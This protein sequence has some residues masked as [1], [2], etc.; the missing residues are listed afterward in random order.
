MLFSTANLGY[1]IP[2]IFIAMAI[3]EAMHAFIA[4]ALGDTTAKDMGRLTLNP[5]KHID[6][7]YTL[8]LPVVLIL[9]GQSPIFAAKPVPF[10][11]N[12]V[13]YG[14]YGAALVG[15]AG[16]VTNFVLA[17]FS[18]ILLR[19]VQM[20]TILDNFMSIFLIIN[21][22]FF[23][24]NMIPIPPLDGSRVLYAFAPEPLQKI[25]AKIESLGFVVILIVLIVLLPALDPAITYLE[26][27]VL[28]LLLGQSFAV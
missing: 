21:V 25:M 22:A 7:V 17:T 20:P 19:T 24:F 10:D 14:E 12:R 1:I 13:K 5:L 18:A 15:L 26:S 9:F 11:P 8:L 3:H 2:A 23:I 27:K 28:Q 16:P 4:H 6:V